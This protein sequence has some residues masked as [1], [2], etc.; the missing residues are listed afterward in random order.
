MTKKIKLEKLRIDGGTQARVSLNLDTVKDYAEAMTAGV[1]FPPITVFF[2]GLD[3]WV[4]DGFHRLK[5]AREI[6]AVD[7]DCDLQQ[8]TLRQAQLFAFAAN[9]SH[10][11]RRS[12]AD[13]RRA[14]EG[15][16][17]IASDWSDR[18]IAAHVGVTHP[19]V[20]GIRNPEQA[21]KQA[22]SRR[23]T[24]SKVETDSTAT[25][26]EEAREAVGSSLPASEP[27]AIREQ[28]EPGV[29]TVS[30]DAVE[31]TP[32]LS[33]L[34]DEV[35]AENRSL[36]AQVE[37]IAADDPRA[38][39]AKWRRA[40]DHAQREQ[41]NAMQRAKESTDREA[42]VMKQLAACGKAVGEEDPKRIAAAVKA[43]VRKHTTVD[44]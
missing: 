39:A 25:I 19:F 11:L 30:T 44:A 32:D 31:D 13:K 15:M 26:Q 16:L 40:F 20:A 24:A 12:N 23:R 3:S 5:A 10:G 17:A 33:Q 37:A 43:F 38:E 35:Q 2:D 34:I 22:E 29:V 28:R 14:V 27:A 9:Q 4:A 18:R 1:E 7:I 42:W 36:Q 21:E 8:G 6:G 41:S